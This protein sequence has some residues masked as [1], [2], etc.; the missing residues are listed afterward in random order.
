MSDRTEQ[1]KSDAQ[2][3][4]GQLI[5]HYRVA[6]HLGSG[7]MGEVFLAEDT[8][9][10]RSVALK[11]L[12][13]EVAED[14][15]RRK[16]FLAE[17]KA[18]SALNHSNVCIIY[19]VGETAE[20]QPF[21]AMEYL[22][23]QALDA[24]ARRRRLEL[25]EIVGIGVQV[26]DALEAARQSQVVH[27]DIKPG[28]I[29]VQEQKAESGKQKSDSQLRVK[30]LDFGLAKRLDQAGEASVLTQEG[31]I[32]GTPNYLSPELAL[33]REVDSRSDIFSLGVVLY[34]LAAGR[35]PFA[36]ASFGDTVNNLLN[37]QPEPLRGWNPTVT[38]EFERIVL[39]CLEK[40]VAKRYATPRELGAD[41]R[42]LE[43][44]RDRSDARNARLV[45]MATAGGLA[46]C[47]L[48]LFAWQFLRSARPVDDKNK[49]PA[50][51]QTA[52]APTTLSRQRLV[53]LPF[54]SLASGEANEIFTDGLAVELF[55]KLSH[56]RGLQV[57]DGSGFV[58]AQGAEKDFAAKWRELNAGALLKGTV[59]KEQK[60]LRIRLQ[61]LDS[62]TQELLKAFDFDR[63]PESVL[64]LQTEAAE[65]IAAALQVQLLAD[66]RLQL[67]RRPTENPRAYQ[68]YLQGRAFW[69]RYTNPGWQ[70]SIELFREA[71]RLDPG[72][73]LAYA[74]LADSYVQLS[75]DT[76]PP[77]EGFTIAKTNALRAIELQPDLA[78]AYVSLA[79]CQMWFDRD[80]PGAKQAFETALRLDP[81]YPDTC[82]FYAHYYECLGQMPRALELLQQA[83]EYDPLMPI[84]QAEL[85]WAYYHARRY[86]DGAA[87][88]RKVLASDPTFDYAQ[89]VLGMNLTRTGQHDE[90][91]RAL[92]KGWKSLEWPVLLGELGYAYA[93]AGRS[94]QAREVLQQLRAMEAGGAWLPPSALGIVHLGLGETNEALT[95]L[96]RAVETHDL[97]MAWV[98]VEPQFDPVR[99]EPRFQALLRKMNLA[100]E[101]AANLSAPG[102][103][104][105]AVL[106]FVNVSGDKAD[107]P[108][109][110]GITDEL[111][112]TL[113]PVNGLQVK[114]R[115]SSFYFKGRNERLQKIGQDLQV[116]YLV[117]GTVSRAG[118]KLRIT[119]DLVTAADESQLW[120]TNYDRP[121]D[122][123]LAIRTDVAT[124]VAESLKGKLLGEERQQLA[125][126]GTENA[127]AYRLYLQGRYL[128]NRR[129]CKEIM[130]AIEY[131]NQAIAKDP[132]Y[133]MAYS[134]LADCYNVLPFYM[135]MPRRDAYPK[136]RAAALEALKLD[137]NLA[138]PHAALA[139]IKGSL[140]WDWAG[141]EV[142]FRRAIAL[143]PNYATAHQWFSSLLD[144][145]GRHDEA[146]AEIRQAQE[147]DPL[148]R[149]INATL[150]FQLF[151]TGKADAAVEVLRKQIAFD[152][153]FAVAHG[154]LGWIHYYQGRFSEA[155][156]EFETMHKLD[157]S[158]TFALEGLGSAYARVGR[159][160]DAQNILAQIEELQRQGTDYRVGTA[161][162]QYVLGDHE[163]ALDSL[164]KGMTERAFGVEGLYSGLGWEVL[165]PH[166]RFQAILRKMNLV[167]ASI[168][169]APP[170]VSQK[171][172]A[173]LPFVNMSSDKENEYLSDGMTEEVL[174]VLAK[175]KG[176]KVPA[177]TSCFVFKGKTDDIRKIG[178]QLGVATVLEGSVRKAGDQLRITAQLINVADGFHLW[179][180][181][182]DRDMTNIFTIQSDIASRV[183]DAL[184]VQLLGAVTEPTRNIEAYKLY[185]QGRYLWNRRTSEAIKQAIEHFNQA[186]AKDPGYALAYAGLADCYV[187]LAEYASLPTRETLPK[188]R[189]AALKALELDSSLA[190][191]RAAL[192]AIKGD[193]WD[194]MGSE[195]EYRKAIALNPNYATAHH[196]LALLL[197][198]MRRYDDALAEIKL[199]QE[200]DPL[201]PVINLNVGDMLFYTG[202]TD[203][204]IE[205]LKEQ[206]TLDPSFAGAHDTLGSHYF[207][208]GRLPEAI[209]EF[210]TGRRLAGQGS[211]GLNGLGCAYARAGRTNEAQ[212]IL[213]QMLELQ[214]QGLDLRVGIAGVQH[215]L[216][217]DEGALGALE[218]ALA[219][220]AYGL[221][222]LNWGLS[223]KD[224][225]PHPRAQAILKQMNLVK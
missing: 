92:E 161:W 121:L 63:E 43:T 60:Q 84:L 144:T 148:S 203:L 152:P 21:I 155:L 40:D 198:G 3:L 118:N 106:P 73:A 124:R 64:A 32:L 1:R 114:G 125:K 46:A 136:S 129:T 68:A 89:C 34:E 183:A 158:G 29:V 78:P 23:G 141:A 93:V 189:A 77:S 62:Q 130:Q 45:W 58:K 222:A 13:K 171:S 76:L 16:R 24:L 214:G 202:R 61:L 120:A 65:V 123:L 207:M 212:K 215:E 33:G 151:Q 127:E 115:A 225:R 12:P 100:P 154:N 66:E 90:A 147:L 11:L 216:G 168:T 71:I 53:L 163:S 81:R 210:E 178:E 79:Q 75:G 143:N 51:A 179:S 187:V 74:G 102:L 30:V 138:E 194:W 17:A 86:T 7:G 57:I 177:R 27:R 197:R 122:D 201:S 48:V 80:Y 35:N 104:S 6:R 67:S 107:E 59:L 146:L 87:Q 192:A 175:V 44:A 153:S 159:T 182:Y 167:P 112:S 185:L 94:Q 69:N 70:R 162:L 223:W 18:A 186:I 220:H 133:A 181:T 137:G 28:N 2:S 113:Q 213:D 172:V 170:A 41:L 221:D 10:D 26:A 117:E 139:D 184:K 15:F 219:E 188:A 116:K 39:K 196:W 5:A 101:P 4:S 132:G 126:R 85:G 111:I 54:K 131:F 9:L 145:L 191:P 218:K 180:V 173:V 193:H 95:Q 72:F 135:G 50:A 38:P 160:N 190:E 82:H 140:D 97:Y 211:Y 49:T 200:L 25:R 8:K 56:I 176:L 204:G 20:G 206:I 109:S 224:L 19:E 205:V 134:G 164:E 174:N 149:I 99:N 108:L 128:W 36:G 105:V 119:V 110:D 150:G 88:C 96:K 209:A 91:I 31:A 103:K 217:D 83:I 156:A 47:L 42:R 157:E 22:E 166:P 37:R 169:S 142:E 55:S 208:Q 98:Q 199:A 165:R 195:E 14:A 52:R